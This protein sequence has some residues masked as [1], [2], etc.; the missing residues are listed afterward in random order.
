MKKAFILIA[1]LVCISGIAHAQDVYFAGNADTIGKIWKN[2]T[3]I[4]SISDSIS[5]KLNDL[6]PN[7]NG[8][9][10]TAG[11]AYD[12]SQGFVLGRIWTNES[13]IFTSD[14]NTFFDHLVI[15]DEGWTA[16][17]GNIVWHNGETLYTYTYGEESC[18]INSIAINKTNNDFFAGGTIETL[19]GDFFACIWE[20]D[21]ILWLEE[22]ISSVEDICFDG[23]N[24]YAA[25]FF[26][27]GDT[28]YGIIW[29]NDSILVQTEN[30]NF[31]S[32]ASYEGNLYWAGI[33]NDTAYVWQDDEILYTHPNYT[34][35]NNLTANE[36]GI[37]Y[38]GSC[39]G[40]A[41]VFKDGEILYQ[42]EGCSNIIGLG[43]IPS[44][45]P[46]PTF[47]LTVGIDSLGGGTVT[48]GGTYHYGDTAT[49]EAI[50]YTGYEFL[51]WND[52]IV[53]NPHDIII[54]QDTTF[55]AHFNRYAYTIE[56]AVVPINS[57]TVAGGG[58]YP[59]GST[60]TLEAIANSGYEF[61]HWSDSI[62]DNPRDIVVT[63]DSSFVAMFSLRQYTITVVSD[64]PEWGSVTGGGTFNFGDTIQIAATANLG[65][66]FVSWNDD[67]TDNP[68]EIIV[69]EDITYTAHFGI[70]QCFIDTKVDPEGAGTINGGGTYDYGSTVYLTVHNNI[71]YEFESWE[72]GTI[73]NPRTI[74]VEGDAVYTAKF[75]PLPYEITTESNPVEGGTVS[76]A[77]T[78]DY[79]TIATLIATPNE[80]YSFLCWSDGIVSNPRHVTVTG[81][82]H[83]KALFHLNGTPQYTLTVTA[84]DPTLGTVSGS[85]TYPQG[86]TIEISA[87]PNVGAIFS[88]WDDG[89]TDNPRLITIT[90]NMEIIAIFEKI[91]TYTIT[92]RAESPLLGTTYGSGVY[93]LNQVINIGATPNSGFF[94]SGWQDGNMDNPR[95]IIVTGN[96]EYIASFAQNPIATYTITVYCNETQGFIL[97]AG[98]Y[99][100][101]STAT[102]AA[103]PADGYVFSRW[104]DDTTDNPKEILV[105]HDIILSAFFDQVGIDENGLGHI[106]LFPNPAT[107]KI[108]IEGLEGK[109]MVQIYDSF[110]MLINTF[111]INGD[112]EICIENLSAGLYIIRING[113][114]M[115]L[116]KE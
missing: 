16:A 64:H 21:T 24:L 54:T 114:A 3:L 33:Q 30:A 47:T 10:Y 76:G 61:I 66:E 57:G 34:G 37:Y 73:N 108:R 46:Q 98:S 51:Y 17:G 26:N 29:Q 13:C 53:T 100:A 65:F 38:S 9:V 28:W 84:N 45:V 5:I 103:I 83:Y 86:A 4:Y 52:G 110:G 40:I 74:F 93:P 36:F 109:Y 85:G 2:D 94:F 91:E 70:Q 106:K 81:N 59:Y 12:Y 48:G 8:T 95:T 39:D 111:S 14:T 96:A 90:Q 87:A 112:D 104:S 71:G 58:T 113:L 55:T 44:E 15:N 11:Y 68:R 63:Q 105:D 99:I 88:R 79:G 80:N 18:H 19:E 60:I 78:Y 43:V 22:Q 107:D 116:M 97:G 56:T 31:Y 41:T 75:S 77:G 23:E 35:I 72:D 7:H 25:G 89:S 92:V 6:Q 115:K 82:A 102:I 27:D 1:A 49:I 101:G 32:I 50:P 69:T 42:P 67:D 20:N 62:T